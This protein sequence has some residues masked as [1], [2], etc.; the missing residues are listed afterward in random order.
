MVN[1]PEIY[2]KKITEIWSKYHKY[3]QRTR[4]MVKIPDLK[5]I[6]QKYG[7]SAKNMVNIPE[8]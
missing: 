1:I 2:I 4:N 7:Q 6:Y 5:P 3:V 8:I